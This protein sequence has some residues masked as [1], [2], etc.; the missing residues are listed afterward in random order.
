MNFFPYENIDRNKVDILVK[1]ILKLLLDNNVT[2]QEADKIGL[3]LYCETDMQKPKVDRPFVARENL[4]SHDYA[5]I[6]RRSD[7]L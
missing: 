5:E 4:E 7:R 6:Y 1:Q 2:V 3:I